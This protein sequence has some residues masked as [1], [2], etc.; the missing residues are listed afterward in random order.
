M[1]SSSVR[2]GMGIGVAL[3]AIGG[4]A[5]QAVGADLYSPSNFSAMVSD[6]RAERVGDSLTIVINQTSTATNSNKASTAKSNSFAG[7]LGL[8]SSTAQ[9]LQV[10][11]A[12]SF[13]GSGQTSHA[14]KM[15]AQLS[16]VVQEVLP[17]GDL[18]VAG[19]QSLNL[20][21]E[22]THI[23][24]TGRVRAADIS[25]TNSVLSSSLA[26]AVIDYDGK[27]FVANSAKPGI[28]TRIFNWLGLI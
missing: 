12:S 13:D 22:R 2:F 10:G 19:D 1:K 3:L 4:A 11:G 20:N 16:V 28:V 8:G 9:S 17:N 27:G 23:K 25:S 26:D 7:H 5:S 14:G 24:L 6:R 15:I 21:G 18:R